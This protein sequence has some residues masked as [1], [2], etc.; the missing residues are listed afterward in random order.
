MEGDEATLPDLP[1]PTDYHYEEEKP[2]FFGHYWLS[3]TPKLSSTS[4]ACLDFSVAKGGFLTAYRWSGE[5]SLS[6]SNIVY[7]PALIADGAG[8]ANDRCAARRRGGRPACEAISKL[9][10]H[11]R[12]LPNCKLL[13]AIGSIRS[14][15]GE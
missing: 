4:A 5:G 13:R 9:R 3:G 7:E 8:L 1:V 2:V 15:A 14:Q 6:S 11:R 12:S 10:Q